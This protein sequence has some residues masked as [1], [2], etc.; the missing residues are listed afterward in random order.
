MN[1]RWQRTGQP[2]LATLASFD[3]FVAKLPQL[4][5]DLNVATASDVYAVYSA[6]HARGRAPLATARSGGGGRF[7]YLVANMPVSAKVAA[8][9]NAGSGDAAQQSAQQPKP[10]GADGQT[11]VRC[12]IVDCLVS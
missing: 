6:L 4:P 2:R 5:R 11:K 3:D 8:A 12:G 1:R 9:G 10:D 7:W